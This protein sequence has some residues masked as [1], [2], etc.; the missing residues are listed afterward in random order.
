MLKKF[1]L[2]LFLL[3]IT[4][5]SALCFTACNKNSDEQGLIFQQIDGKKEYCVVG[6]ED[7][8]KEDI[9]IPTEYKGLPVTEIDRDSFQ[10]SKITTV[11]IPNNI[12][13]IHNYAFRGHECNAL[14]I[15]CQAQLEPSGWSSSWNDYCPV[16]WNC[17]N[18][19][20]ADDGCV[21]AI[22]NGI[23]YALKENATV[24][25]QNT[26]IS[27]AN[28]PDMV[29]YNEKSYQVN[30]IDH[31]AFFKCE[32]LIEVYM[33]NSITFI[34]ELAFYDCSNLTNIVISNGITKIRRATF[35]G[36]SS[37][38]NIIIPS[39]ITYIAT[40]AFNN[41]KTLKDIIIPSSVT[42]IEKEAFTNCNSLTN[43]T[44]ESPSSWY[45]TTSEF[46]WG[47]SVGGTAFDL[48]NSANNA[49]Y[50]KS[51]YNGYYWYKI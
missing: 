9:V 15:Y 26:K 34:G 37:L 44:F 28:I 10:N 39:N 6:L 1:V 13:K 43:I 24:V 11:T 8:C 50:F 2:F 29:N 14:T 4:L 31:S 32:N 20:I 38:K 27:T 12:I 46:N 21:Y 48:S 5:C 33:S 16:V 3:I 36:C 17:D 35:S 42:K 41:C 45:M 40:T 23:R 18:N 25:G 22:I 49:N 19:E 47:Y 7:D 30:S 51:L